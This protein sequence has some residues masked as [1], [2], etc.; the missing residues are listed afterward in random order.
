MVDKTFDE[1]CI[2]KNSAENEC[3]EH[4]YETQIQIFENVKPVEMPTQRTVLFH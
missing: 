2:D 1:E 4:Q 3:E